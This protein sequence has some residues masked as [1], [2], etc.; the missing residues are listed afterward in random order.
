MSG[1]SRSR[2]TPLAKGP[3][4]RIPASAVVRHVDYVVD[5]DSIRL[6]GGRYVRFIGIL[7]PEVGECGYRKAK[8]KPDQWVGDTAGGVDRH[9]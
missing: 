7:T 1:P 6:D 8:R 4:G 9:R 3:A 2:V 5:G